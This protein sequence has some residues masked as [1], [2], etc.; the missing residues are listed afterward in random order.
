MNRLALIADVHGNIW[1]LEAVLSDSRRRRIDHIFDLG[2]IAQGSLHPA[3]T[4]PTWRCSTGVPIARTGF[5]PAARGL[6]EDIYDT[7][8]ARA[9][10][11]AVQRL[12]DGR[13]RR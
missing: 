5:A 8:N 11:E 13:R 4:P 6:A 1:A 12:P 9:D 2:D 3:D 10:G 7:V